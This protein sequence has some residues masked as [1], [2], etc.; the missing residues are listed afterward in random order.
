MQGICRMNKHRAIKQVRFPGQIAGRTSFYHAVISLLGYVK[1]LNK[2]ADD[3]ARSGSAWTL[4]V[5]G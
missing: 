2:D 5:D 1:D 3:L 4:S